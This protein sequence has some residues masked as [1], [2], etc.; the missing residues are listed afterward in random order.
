M[1]DEIF[2]IQQSRW[3]FMKVT[4][5]LVRLA[6][7]DYRL[8]CCVEKGRSY[9]LFNKNRSFVLKAERLSTFKRAAGQHTVRSTG[10]ITFMAFSVSEDLTLCPNACGWVCVSFCVCVS[11]TCMHVFAVLWILCCDQKKNVWMPQPPERAFVTWPRAAL[12][13]TSFTIVSHEGCSADSAVA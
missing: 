13:K 9:I 2:S 3:G 8:F 5:F 7:G 12:R 4:S 6:F 1:F 10:I 11:V